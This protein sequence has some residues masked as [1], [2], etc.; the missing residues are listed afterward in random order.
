M[1]LWGPLYGSPDNPACTSGGYH[2]V[3]CTGDFKTCSCER[4]GHHENEPMKWWEWEQLRP[5]ADSDLEDPCDC[6]RNEPGD[7]SEKSYVGHM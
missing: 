3:V 4:R 5:L 6:S 7:R 1:G 2:F